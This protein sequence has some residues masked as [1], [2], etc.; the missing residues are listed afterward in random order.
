MLS[1][2]H[3]HTKQEP[4][5]GHTRTLVENVIL[6]CLCVLIIDLALMPHITGVQACFH[7]TTDRCFEAAEST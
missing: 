4:L 2:H 5:L 1:A 6:H 7:L 3:G